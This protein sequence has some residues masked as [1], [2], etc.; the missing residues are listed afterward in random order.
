[1]TDYGT[2]AVAIVAGIW[3]SE[4]ARGASFDRINQIRD[5]ILTGILDSQKIDESHRQVMYRNDWQPLARGVPVVSLLFAGVIA[6]APFLDPCPPWQLI[7]VCGVVSFYQICYG[8]VSA[9]TFFQD[10]KAI[11]RALEEG[12]KDFHVRFPNLK[13]SHFLE[14][15]WWGLDHLAKENA[16]IESR[17][18]KR[19]QL[20]PAG[21]VV[22]LAFSEFGGGPE[23]TVV[24]NYFVWYANSLLSFLK[25]FAKAYPSAE[26]WRPLF[27]EVHKWRNKVSAH[28]AYTD[29]RSDDNIYSQEVSIL[30]TPDWEDDC[31]VVGRWITAG[32]TGHSHPDWNWSLTKVHAELIAYIGRNTK[33]DQS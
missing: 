22:G 4:N 6:V 7:T 12:K 25:I 17:V 16:N 2:L 9:W 20:D 5:R 33:H 23:H 30:M 31:F 26:D 32:A 3:A 15:L 13:E 19:L 27:P 10:S 8:L 29:P 28:T 24:L 1:M 14:S 11:R 21:H 18:R